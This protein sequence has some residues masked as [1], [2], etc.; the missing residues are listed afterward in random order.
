DRKTL[1]DKLRMDILHMQGFLTPATGITQVDLGLVS[2]A[3]PNGIFPTAAIHEFITNSP[4]TAAAS[5]AFISAITSTLAAAGGAC[6]WI[7]KTRRVFPPALKTFGLN[8]EQ[9]VFVGTKGDNE[10]LWAAEQALKSACVAAVIAEIPDLTA[11]A[12]RRLQLAVE[13]TH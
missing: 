13:K 9:V 1:L 6:I 2:E 8:P 3:F 10:A 7:H 12:S 11:I 4:E 5:G